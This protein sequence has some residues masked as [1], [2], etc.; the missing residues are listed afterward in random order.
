MENL[1]PEKLFHAKILFPDCIN[2]PIAEREHMPLQVA[3]HPGKSAAACQKIVDKSPNSYL[4]YL[5]YYS[6]CSFK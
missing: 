2:Y 4:L 6:L 3:G 5:F 1:V